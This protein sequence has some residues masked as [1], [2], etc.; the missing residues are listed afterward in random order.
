M[1]QFPFIKMLTSVYLVS[2]LV[3]VWVERQDEEIA[4]AILNF[5]F[6]SDSSDT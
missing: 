4:H 3:R 2:F 6:N 5:Y 1:F